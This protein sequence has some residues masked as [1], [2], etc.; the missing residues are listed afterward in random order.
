[1]I[2]TIT[3][4]TEML[5]LKYAADQPD[6]YVIRDPEPLHTVALSPDSDKQLRRLLVQTAR[7]NPKIIG[8]IPDDF[9]FKWNIQSNQIRRFA[10]SLGVISLRGGSLEFLT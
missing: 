3:A 2:E 6:R 5:F 4:V 7:D 10:E 9:E 8:I 1:V